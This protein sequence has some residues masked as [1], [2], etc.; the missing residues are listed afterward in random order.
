MLFIYLGVQIFVKSF[1]CLDVVY[2]IS[3]CLTHQIP[4]LYALIQ[5]FV[6]KYDSLLGLEV[7]C[8]SCTG[9][10][11]VDKGLA[12]SGVLVHK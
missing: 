6:Q 1:T 11:F 2:N 7:L 3:L 9:P 8:C 10:R 5:H 4:S 12:M